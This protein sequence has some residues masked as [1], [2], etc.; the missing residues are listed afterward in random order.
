[1]TCR[2]DRKDWGKAEGTI[3]KYTV[4]DTQNTEYFQKVGGSV[5]VWRKKAAEKYS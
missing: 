2:T 3:W 4:G 1:M 5:A